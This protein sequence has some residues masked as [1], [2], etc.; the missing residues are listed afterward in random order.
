M[1]AKVILNSVRRPTQCCRSSY[2]TTGNGLVY[3]IC[4]WPQSLS[5]PITL[6]NCRKPFLHTQRAHTLQE[7]KMAEPTEEEMLAQAIAMSLQESAKEATVPTPQ[8]TPVTPAQPPSQTLPTTNE[9]ANLPTHPTTPP[10]RKDSF[11]IASEASEIA[12]AILSRD[13][14][15]QA[16]QTD[17]TQLPPAVLLEREWRPNKEC[18]DLVMGMGISENAARRALYHT[19]N[20]NAELAT[21]WV[22]ENIDNPE[23]HS[24]FN[25]GPI[26]SPA[27]TT[28]LG[29]PG[30]PVYHS[31]DDALVGAPSE[32]YKMVFVVNTDLKM[33]VGKIAAQVGHATLALYRL[34]QTQPNWKEQCT[35]WEETAMTKIAVQGQSTHHL[36]ELK[37]RAY[38]LRL[39]SVIVHDAGRTQVEPGSLTVFAVFGRVADINEITGKLKLL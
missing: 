29:Q 5:P 9:A 39:P 27:G 34:L 37:H 20:D 12:R 6:H 14:P 25:P 16:Q 31:F 2:R 30:W 3:V 13:E 11:N 4:G 8:S 21:A 28:S 36:L 19:G 22:F 32:L 10:A 35:K 33:G 26:T 17:S 15:L 1:R 7:D 18:L 24:P 38:E 23:L